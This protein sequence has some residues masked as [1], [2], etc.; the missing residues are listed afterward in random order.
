MRRRDAL[1]L[2]LLAVPFCTGSEA[3]AQG[4]SKVYRL[5]VLSPSPGSLQ[6]MRALM[7]PELA[8]LGFTE[9]QNLVVEARFGPTEELPALA[10]QIVAA[11]PDAIIATGIAIRAARQA[12]STTPIIGLS[13]GEDPIVAGFAA[14]LARPGGNVTGIV[15]LA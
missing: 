9:G 8:R 11:R 5:G 1:L 3:V 15:M 14:S 13:I 12:T 6:R 7:F 10:R 2:P 4:P